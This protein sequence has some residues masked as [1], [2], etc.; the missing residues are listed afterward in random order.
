MRM[1]PLY[2]IGSTPAATYQGYHIPT[3]FLTPASICYCEG[4]GTDISLDVEQVSRFGSQVYILIPC[5]MP[6]IITGNWKKIPNRSNHLLQ[7]RA[8]RFTPIR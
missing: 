2:K 3:H 8:N 6:F 7:A 1:L 4:A 5:P